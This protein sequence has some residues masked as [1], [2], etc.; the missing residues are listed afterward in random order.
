MLGRVKQVEKEG[1]FAEKAEIKSKLLNNILTNV[2][3]TLEAYKLRRL[4]DGAKD[5]EVTPIFSMVTPSGA[6]R[7]YYLNTLLNSPIFRVYMREA[8]NIKFSNPLM[9]ILEYGKY[10]Q[11]N[12]LS[13]AVDKL[14][15]LT[16]E[17][18][19]KLHQEFSDTLLIKQYDEYIK[20][21][22]I[23]PTKINKNAL[24]T[25]V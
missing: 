6:K 12:I 17:Q 5:I 14:K 13:L 16:L 7:S 4:T 1:G 23:N 11:K 24:L 15:P 8:G 10:V 3:N 20:E 9:Q 19:R 2:I 25:N 21:N 22:N 18:Y